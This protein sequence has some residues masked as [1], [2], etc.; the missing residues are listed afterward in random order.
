MKFLVSL[1]FAFLFSVAAAAQDVVVLVP[2]FFNSFAPEYF[3]EDI[4]R[5]FQKKDFKVY[6]ITGLNPIGTIEENGAKVTQLLKSIRKA[7]LGRINIVAHSAGGFYSLLAIQNGGA[8]IQNLITISTPY[9]GLD[10]LQA[11]REGSSLFTKLTDLASLQGL[12]QLTPQYTENFMKTV[13]VPEKLNIYTYGGQQPRNLDIWNAKNL[14]GVLRITA[15]YIPNETDGI[16]SLKSSL[17]IHGL[18]TISNKAAKM[19]VDRNFLMSLEH[20]EQ[21]LDYRNFILLGVRNIDVI[22][23][24]QIYFYNQIADLIIKNPTAH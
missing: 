22:R 24:R 11:W 17:G 20:W 19:F 16:V 7:E 18:Q 23:D 12:R 10:F 15:H 9:L 1:L 14:S 13:R 3:S 8:D 2:G 21:V 6:V 5:C 4:I